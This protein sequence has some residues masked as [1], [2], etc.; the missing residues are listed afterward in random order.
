MGNDYLQIG[1][2]RACQP[3][4]PGVKLLNNNSWLLRVERTKS[5][6]GWNYPPSDDTN[7]AATVNP[8]A[9]GTA[10]RESITES[11]LP[12]NLGY[13]EVQPAGSKGRA[14]PSG[15]EQPQLP[16]GLLLFIIF[17]LDLFE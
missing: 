7:P 15:L 14:L 16:T 2:V 3:N 6:K 17:F 1:R 5:W 4:R 10:M 12:Q 9:T 8:T 13:R 11:G